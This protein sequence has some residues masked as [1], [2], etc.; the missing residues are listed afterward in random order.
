M[1][2]QWEPKLKVFHRTLAFL[3]VQNMGYAHCTLAQ[4]NLITSFSGFQIPKLMQEVAFILMESGRGGYDHANIRYL[5]T[6]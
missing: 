5:C 6:W 1:Y 4:T 2:V 3:C